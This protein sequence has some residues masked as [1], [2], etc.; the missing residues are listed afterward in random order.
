MKKWRPSRAKAR[1]FAENMADPAFKAA[2]EERKI[3][4]ADRRR[5]TSAFDYN[6]AGGYYHPTKEQ[7]AAAFRLASKTGI[8]P[9]QREACNIVMSCFT[10]GE[11]A[12][13]DYI[14][15]VNEFIRSGG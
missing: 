13:H 4:W 10:S 8:T 14:H 6:T 12:H 1:E 9:E 2:Y 11:K 5:A 3:Q 7:N 15:V